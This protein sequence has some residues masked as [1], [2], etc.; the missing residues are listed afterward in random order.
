MQDGTSDSIRLAFPATPDFS[1]IGRVGVAGLA[2]RLGINV[3]Q[4]ERLRIAVDDCVE[5]LEGPGKIT[6]VARWEPGILEV[7][8]T[9]PGFSPPGTAAL[10]VTIAGLAELVDQV[11]THPSGLVLRLESA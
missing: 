10:D 2:L 1:R 3:Q 8:I 7:E 11:T 9:R 5:L 4:V 6:I